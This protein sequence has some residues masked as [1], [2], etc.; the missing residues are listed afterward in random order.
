M[1]PRELPSAKRDEKDIRQALLWHLRNMFRWRHDAD[2]TPNNAR[3][4][5]ITSHVGRTL[6]N[7]R[8]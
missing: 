2:G 7:V 5:S 1:T 4:L 3:A 8:R 6:E